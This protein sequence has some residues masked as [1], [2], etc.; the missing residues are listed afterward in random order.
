MTQ[1]FADFLGLIEANSPP[2][3]CPKGGVGYILVKLSPE[4]A[5][6]CLKTF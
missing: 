4:D 1:I 6:E 2:E 5:F 3:G